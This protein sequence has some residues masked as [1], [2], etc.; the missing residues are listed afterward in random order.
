MSKWHAKSGAIYNADGMLVA[1]GFL[2]DGAE[3]VCRLV[4]AESEIVAALERAR[5]TL[6]HC[7]GIAGHYGHADAAEQAKAADEQAFEALALLR[8]DAPAPSVESPLDDRYTRPDL[9]EHTGI[10]EHP[11]AD[12]DVVAALEA[13]ERALIYVNWGSRDG[14]ELDQVRAALAKVRG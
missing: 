7:G 9:S 1:S 13:A 2:H 10:N 6:L 12:P 14:D 8:G 5:R 3:R 11:P 4:N